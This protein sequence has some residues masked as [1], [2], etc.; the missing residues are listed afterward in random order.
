MRNKLFELVNVHENYR[1]S[2]INMIPSEN[3]MSRT[4]R[5]ALSSDLGHRYHHGFFY[6]GQK[7]IQEIISK[8]RDLLS[9]L[10]RAEYVFIE[11]L[12]GNIAL[13][14][15][16]LA[17]TRENDGIATLSFENGGYPFN[18]QRLHRRA[19]YLPFNEE[20]GTIDIEAS[21]DIIY[22]ERPKLIILGASFI[23]FP[24]PVKEIAEIAEDVGAL[25]IYDGSH[26]LGLIAGN[27][28]Q[29]PLREGADILLGSTHKTF[30]GPQGGII[31]TNN[32]E[33]YETL[34][35]FLGFPPVM[36][37]NPHINRIAAL[38]G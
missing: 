5:M 34:K 20:E 17:F 24:H 36:V 8:T 22:R 19:I 10:F 26:V 3:V 18:Y 29:D 7:Y 14:T 12:S 16:I 32:D 35:N 23:L 2:V 25:T 11:P 37:D 38:G 4:A 9:K 31:I 30:P 15:V 13:L 28:F 1:E 6:G 33:I 27:S 21:K